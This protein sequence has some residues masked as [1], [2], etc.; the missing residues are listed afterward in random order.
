[1][2]NGSGQGNANLIFSM[3]TNATNLRNK[4]EKKM[5]RTTKNTFARGPWMQKL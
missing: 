2:K 4:E 5:L 3:S 1:M